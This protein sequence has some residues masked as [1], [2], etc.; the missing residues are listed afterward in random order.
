MIDWIGSTLDLCVNGVLLTIIG[1]AAGYRACL[2]I[3]L[4]SLFVLLW[5]ICHGETPAWF[6]LLCDES[7]SIVS[8]LGS[9][10]SGEGVEPPIP[11]LNLLHCGIYCIISMQ[12]CLKHLVEYLSIRPNTG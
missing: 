5:M 8:Q 6:A 2:Y 9:L 3:Q 10:L 12:M 4:C 7:H 1:T 11:V